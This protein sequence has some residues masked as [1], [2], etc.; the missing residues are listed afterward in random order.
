LNFGMEA[1]DQF[2]SVREK[3]ARMVNKSQQ[4]FVN[5]IADGIRKKVFKA[6]WNYKE[7][8]TLFFAMIEGGVLISK[9]TKKNDK[10]DIIRRNL[11]K[12]IEQQVI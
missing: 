6:D 11:K 10:M 3:V 5:I 8:A 2:E 1:D 7:F 4:V 9:T 12:M